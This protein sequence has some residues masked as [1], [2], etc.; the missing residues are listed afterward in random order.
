MFYYTII[1]YHIILIYIIFNFIIYYI[2]LYYTILNYIVYVIYLYNI[3]LCYFCL[4]IF[5]ACFNSYTTES[6]NFSSAGYPNKYQ[7]DLKCDYRIKVKQGNV[8]NL[9]FHPFDLEYSLTCS[10]DYLKIYNVFPSSI[11]LGATF[12]G[13]G[14][15][16]FRSNS[17]EILIEFRSDESVSGNGF[18]A[19]YVAVN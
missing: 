15:R 2:I 9:N 13:T 14:A 8:I 1:L 12:C 5:L 17:S 11:N 4:F 10:Y 18:F 19:S 7:N 6:G 16:T 3:M